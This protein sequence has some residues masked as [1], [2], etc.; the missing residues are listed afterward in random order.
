MKEALKARN[1]DKSSPK[2]SN[3][4]SDKNSKNESQETKS[5]KAD[6]NL[7]EKTVSQNTTLSNNAQDITK[8]TA[9]PKAP[10]AKQAEK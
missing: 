10:K 6:A 9:E 2:S 8:K 1:V 7:D 3:M 5:P 4:S